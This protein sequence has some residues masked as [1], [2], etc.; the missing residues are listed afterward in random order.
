MNLVIA[1]VAVFSLSFILTSIVKYFAR[2][3][4][5]IAVPRRDRWHLKPTA[6][7][8][9]ISIYVSFI[10][11]VFCFFPEHA[12]IRRLLL[13]G[14]LLF[15]VGLIDDLYQI[16]PYLKL[17]A[18]LIASAAVIF[19]GNYLP[20]TQVILIDVCL[21][22]VWL[23]GLTNALNML[24]NMDG[25][26][27]GISIIACLYLSINF[28]LNSQNNLYILPLILAAAIAGFFLYNFHPASIFM[29]DCGSLFIGFTMAGISLFSIEQRTRNIAAV[30]ATPVLI[31]LLPIFDTTIVTISRKLNGRPVSQGGKD[32]A[33]HRLVAL[34]MSD[35]R[36]VITLYLISCLSGLLAIFVRGLD[37]KVS[38]AIIGGCV[39]FVILLGIYLGKVI[40]YD[41]QIELPEQSFTPFYQYL[42][43]IR[44]AEVVFDF[45][46][47]IL[48]YYV[49]YLLK[50]DG[51]IP[52]YHQSIF[53]RTLPYIT[54][55]YLAS[56]FLFGIYQ[57]S[58]RL[59]GVLQFVRVCKAIIV[60][61]FASLFAAYIITSLTKSSSPAAL[62]SISIIS[63]V[64]IIL[65]FVFSRLSF[66]FFTAIFLGKAT[67]VSNV[68]KIYIYGVNRRTEFLL[69]ELHQ[70]RGNGFV[71]LGFIDKSQ[72]IRQQTFNGHS[73]YCV[74]DLSMLDKSG[75]VVFFSDDLNDDCLILLKSSGMKC[76]QVKLLFD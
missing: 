1:L 64:L 61:S 2:K 63:S 47:V 14:G 70:F 23:V 15:F 21:T 44:L 59:S 41:N 56:F 73:V 7:L 68:K 76:R 43:R 54:A 55:V 11:G 18:Q 17:A 32:H 36:A 35:K 20:W 10:I 25:L 40:V 26:A 37:V 46:L 74:S 39:L 9:G 13:G 49:A 8:G 30:L 34:G 75:V 66:Q 3:F 45:T 72:E 53:I 58:W 67:N 51:Q 31:M 24:D 28:I 29:G 50:Y 4:E 62:I 42:Q 33:S 19:S 60:A 71:M 48:G 22:F 16:K 27:S 57:E 38:I 12:L 6:L 69:N 5:L 65:G 52:Q